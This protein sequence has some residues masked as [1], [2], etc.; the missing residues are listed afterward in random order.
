MVSLL[1]LW[2]ME[3]EFTSAKRQDNSL[4]I[5]IIV[6]ANK[7]KAKIIQYTNKWQVRHDSQ[8]HQGGVPPH[9]VV[10]SATKHSWKCIDFRDPSCK[11]Q[12]AA[13]P[14]WNSITIPWRSIALDT[15]LVRLPSRWP[16]GL[17]SHPGVNCGL[18]KLW[19]SPENKWMNNRN[20]E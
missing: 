3:M 15:L 2:N 11:W 7:K 9:L 8:A 10:W 6:D 1:I 5:N 13:M 12:L 17:Q 19:L 4:I 18:V 20:V 14:L 16:L